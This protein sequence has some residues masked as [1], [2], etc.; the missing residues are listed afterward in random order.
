MYILIDTM[1]VDQ[2]V[3]NN[4]NAQQS[5]AAT[6][7]PVDQGPDAT[8]HKTDDS[9]VAGIPCS[10]QVTSSPAKRRKRNNGEACEPQSPQQKRKSR[11]NRGTLACEECRTRKRRCDG[12]MPTCGSCVKRSSR[13]VYS[14]EIQNK[15][16]QT[17]S[18]LVLSYSEYSYSDGAT[19]L[20]L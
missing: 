15:V 8:G 14:S 6:P 12:E 10:S 11:R 16:W 7:S 4:L 19:A 13:C 3:Q 1:T 5:L 17:R 20:V 9:T 2:S 18:A